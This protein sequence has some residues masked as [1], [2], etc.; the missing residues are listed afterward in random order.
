MSIRRYH[1]IQ[2]FIDAFSRQKKVSYLEIG[3]QRG[4]CFVEINAYRKTAVDPQ[5]LI[6]KRNRLKIRLKNFPHCFHIK[7]FEQTSDGFFDTRQDYIEKI[8]GFDV[9]FIDGLHLYE[10]VVKDVENSLRHLN[11]GGVILLHDCNPVEE[12]ATTRGISSDDAAKR[13]G[14]G[15]SGTWNGDVWKAIVDLRSHRDDLEIMVYDCDCGMGQIRVKPGKRLDVQE[16]E[17]LTFNDL[18]ENRIEWLNLKPGAHYR[19]Y[20]RENLTVIQQG[21]RESN[22]TQPS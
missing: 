8:G 2:A 14:S 19:Q 5:F 22:D 16:I 4:Y 7:Y 17:K 20:I 11:P 21:F 1:I 3:V 10:Q 13:A 12:A 18:Q 9:V 6:G 15:W